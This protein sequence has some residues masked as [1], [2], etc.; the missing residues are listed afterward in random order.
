GLNEEQLSQLFQPFNRLGRQTGKEEGAGIGLVVSK[1][2][3]ELMGGK[4]GV[5]STIG[6]GCLFWF[7]L[8]LA[9]APEMAG[10]KT[11]TKLATDSLVSAGPHKHSMLYVEDNPANLQLVEGILERRSDIRLLSAKNANRGIEIARNA[12]PDII[13]MD[14]NLP[15]ING[16]QALNILAQD[17]TTAHIPV[18]AI[19]ANAMSD[20]IE[21]GLRAGFFRYLTKPIKIDEFLDTVD[22][23]LQIVKTKSTNVNSEEIPQ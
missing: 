15:G 1:R 8:N 20:N 4:I 6:K 12:R 17:P 23:A 5:E 18:I 2:L 13:L 22:A 16:Y 21:K 14:I 9:P 3:V 7:D 11:K 19:S 10:K